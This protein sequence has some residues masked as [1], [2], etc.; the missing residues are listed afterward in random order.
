VDNK[1]DYIWTERLSD[2]ME[3]V[4]EEEVVNLYE[5]CFDYSPYRELD[6]IMA[7]VTKCFIFRNRQLITKAVIAQVKMK[8]GYLTIYYD[9]ERDPYLDGVIKMAEQMAS[10]I[11]RDVWED[12]RKG[13]IR[14]RKIL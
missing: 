11:S 5:N 4:Y 6:E 14:N 1:N 7:F 9:G 12:H 3:P 13:G 2:F 8:W 10:K